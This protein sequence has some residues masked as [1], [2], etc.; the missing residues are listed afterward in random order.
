M[1]SP[2]PG[3]NLNLQIELFLFSV[4]LW[5]VPVATLTDSDDSSD[6]SSEVVLS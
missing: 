3:Y 6:N 4:R 1:N 2:S 5:N